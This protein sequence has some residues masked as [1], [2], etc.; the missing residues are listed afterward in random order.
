[1]LIEL[2]KRIFGGANAGQ[3]GRPP[4]TRESVPVGLPG[5]S[6]TGGSNSYFG[7]MAKLQEAISRHQYRLAARLARE[8]LGQLLDFV[9]ECSTEFGSFDIS[10]IP[11]LQQGGTML[12]LA[13]DD[14]GLSEMRRVVS[15]IPELSRWTEM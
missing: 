2:L 15:A 6:E 14:V 11:V 12:A 5:G 3:K 1:M 9:S 8:N 13:G 10:S 4:S 7:T